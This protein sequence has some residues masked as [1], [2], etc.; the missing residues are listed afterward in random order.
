VLFGGGSGAPAAD[1]AVHALVV[2]AESTARVQELHVLL[3][4][5]VLDQVDRWA[6]AGEEA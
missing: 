2:P 4:H 6:A 3:L 1:H 5:V